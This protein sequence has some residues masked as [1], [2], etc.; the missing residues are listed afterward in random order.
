MMLEMIEFYNRLARLTRD[1]KTAGG[2]PGAQHGERSQATRGTARSPIGAKRSTLSI[3]RKRP[4]G[5]TRTSKRP[6]G[7]RRTSPQDPTCGCAVRESDWRQGC[8]PTTKRP[9][10][11]RS[12]DSPIDRE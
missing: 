11:S 10:R 3:E 8:Q 7:K 2:I 1:F 12:K 5:A 9:Q 4:V 6:Q